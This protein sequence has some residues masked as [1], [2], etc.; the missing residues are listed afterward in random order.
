MTL[1]YLVQ[2]FLELFVVLLNF[3]QQLV[4][5][6][7]VAGCVLQ[8]TKLVLKLLH[9]SVGVRVGGQVI[10]SGSSVR[11]IDSLIDLVVIREDSVTLLVAST[12]LR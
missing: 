9:L 8:F 12:C 10:V 2:I 6:L 4:Q 3:Y 5:F 1:L 7:K 11:V